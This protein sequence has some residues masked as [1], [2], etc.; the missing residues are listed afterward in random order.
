MQ[1]LLILMLA[2]FWGGSFV[3]IQAIVQD[4]PPVAS[5]FWRVLIATAL[6]FVYN[7][8]RH[9]AKPQHYHR[10]AMLCGVI[11]MGIPWSLLFWA[12]QHVNGALGAIMNAVVPIVV[13]LLGPYFNRSTKILVRQW[14][15]ILIAFAGI[16]V[17]FGPKLLSG[18]ASDGLAIM[19][20]VGMVLSY[21][22][23]VL[24]THKYLQ[25]VPASLVA[26][27]Q[28][29]SGGTFLL[30]AALLHG[31]AILSPAFVQVKTVWL[32]IGYLAIFSTLIA[33]I[34]FVKLIQTQGSVVASLVT[35]LIP[36]SS[37]MIEW[38]WLRHAPSRSSLAGLI[39]V[40]L[41]L[42]V[43]QFYKGRRERRALVVPPTEPTLVD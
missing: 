1:I 29:V 36:I 4:A 28:G 17:I 42:Y 40:L 15:G 30:V 33:N 14:V 26:G 19:A 38:I 20:L 3:A 2:G 22:T 43:V 6:T 39:L 12:E 24:Y 23:S 37:M 35:F 10:R 11:S 21:A 31:E 25:G 34:V 5:A 13:L 27:W 9:V 7:K 16:V 32:G 8:M 41:G 18:P